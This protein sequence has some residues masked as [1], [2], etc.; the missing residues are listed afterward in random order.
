MKIKK[1]ATHHWLP[2]TLLTGLLLM[3]SCTALASSQTRWQQYDQQGLALYQQRNY[4]AA[5]QQLQQAVKVAQGVANGAPYQASSL[6]LLAFAQWDAGQHQAALASQAQVIALAQGSPQVAASQLALFLFN[7]G[8][9]FERAK[10]FPEAIQAYQQAWQLQEPQPATQATLKTA[11][12]LAR[13]HNEQKNYA[14]VI[15]VAQQAL[16]KVQNPQQIA[17]E[18][19][20]LTYVLADALYQQQADKAQQ[21]LEN[22]L[23]QQRQQTNSEP[24]ALAQTLERLAWVFDQQGQQALAD[25][26]RAELQQ[27]HQQQGQLSVTTVMNLNELALTQHQQGQFKQAAQY[28]Q[29]ASVQLKQLKH[30]QSL[31]QATIWQ[32]WGAALEEQRDPKQALQLY[33]QSAELYRQLPLSSPQ[34]AANSAGRLATLL[35]QQRQYQVAEEWFLQ[36]L[37]WLEQGS[38]DIETLLIALDNLVAVYQVQGKASQARPYQKRAKQLRKEKRVG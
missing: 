15:E 21:V 17:H 2:Q 24:H 22:Y 3:S 4:S 28:Y 11:W 25:P 19:Q 10:Q 16:A 5:I 26:L 14:S 9:L 18:Q 27:L 1:H 33:Q 30:S 37:N 31:E 23:A 38:A 29:Q 20:Q 32:N 7:Q 12:A 8:D 36:S 35:Y 34:L 6:N 13:L